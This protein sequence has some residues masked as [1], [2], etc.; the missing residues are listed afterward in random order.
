MSNKEQDLRL[1]KQWNRTHSDVDLQNLLRALQPVINQQVTRW[2]GSLARSTLDLK[3]KVLTVEAIK[4]FDPSKNVALATHVT[5]QLQK[6]SRIVYMHTQAARLPEHKAV[7][8]A[9][10]SVAQEQ[11]SNNLGREPTHAE[12]ADQLGWGTTRVKEFQKAYERKE[13]LSSGEFNPASFA[14]ADDEDPVVGYVYHDMSPQDK[15]LFENITGYGGKPRLNNTQIMQKY[16]M[17]Q[18]QLSYRKRQLI[19]MFEKATKGAQ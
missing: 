1:W 3:A 10:F 14:I 7:S 5:N 12:L 15:L 6:L 19:Q 16:N 11:L 9:S 18:G 8:M 2:S 13:L 17:T 4:K